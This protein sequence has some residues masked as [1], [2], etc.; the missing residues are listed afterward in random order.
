MTCHEFE[1]V[2]DELV[3]GTLAGEAHALCV[4]HAAACD[5]CR[6]LV[7]PMGAALDP[8]DVEPPAFFLQSVLRKTTYVPRRTHWAETWRRFML[9]PRIA[10]EVAYVGVVVLSLVS[11]RVNPRIVIDDLRS[12]AGILL[13]RATSLWEKENP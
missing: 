3:R 8:V 1:G 9:R 13:D 7:E 2:L 12:E 6:E 10:S 4:S 5:A 11:I